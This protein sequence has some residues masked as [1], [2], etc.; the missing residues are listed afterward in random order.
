ML[1]KE[2][3]NGWLEVIYHKDLDEYSNIWTGEILDSEDSSTHEKF[4][5]CFENDFMKGNIVHFHKSK[6]LV[7]SET[8]S[9]GYVNC[10]DVIAVYKTVDENGENNE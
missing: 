10:E 7:I 1:K 8:N 2:M 3:V 5:L 9:Q 6:L 4:G